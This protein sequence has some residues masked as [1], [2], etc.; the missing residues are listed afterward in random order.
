MPRRAMF[1]AM[2]EQF[3]S[4]ESIIGNSYDIGRGFDS[5]EETG[6]ERSDGTQT[7]SHPVHAG[8]NAQAFSRR[9][10]ERKTEE[11]NEL[12]QALA[13][14]PDART[15]AQQLCVAK[16]LRIVPYLRA[17]YS[18]EEIFKLAKYF[19]LARHRLGDV[20]FPQG[21]VTDRFIV[22]LEGTFATYTND[23]LLEQ[24]RRKRQ[25]LAKQQQHQAAMQSQLG[26]GSSNSSLASAARAV[27]STS[28]EA[29]VAG[30]Q[31]DRAGAVISSLAM[32]IAAGHVP[33]LDDRLGFSTSSLNEALDEARQVHRQDSESLPNMQLQSSALQAAPPSISPLAMSRVP[34]TIDM[35]FTRAPS[36]EHASHQRSAAAAAV[37]AAN[38][39]TNVYR[40]IRDYA[41]NDVV[42]EES[43]GR[44]DHS[45][46]GLHCER[47]GIV[48]V[49]L[50]TDYRK[51][52][53]E[54]ELAMVQLSNELLRDIPAFMPYNSS[55]TAMSKLVDQ[56]A[57]ERKHKNEVILAQGAPAPQHVHIVLEGQCRAT[58]TIREPRHAT[59]AVATLERGS[60][61]GAAAVLADTAQPV[62]V[63][64]STPF[65][66]LLRI[67]R[68]AFL[69]FDPRT[70]A[71]LRGELSTR[72]EDRDR[73][74]R[75]QM[76]TIEDEVAR[77]EARL[78]AERAEANPTPE[79]QAAS[80][81]A[82]ALAMAAAEHK[83]LGPDHGKSD[84]DFVIHGQ[85]KDAT[86]A[87]DL[88]SRLVAGHE[89][90]VESTSESHFKTMRA[91]ETD[92]EQKRRKDA[93]LER[94]AAAERKRKAQKAL[95]RSR[96]AGMQPGG[97]SLPAITGT[98]FLTE[99]G[100]GGDD[101]EDDDDE[102]EDEEEEEEE[103]DEAADAPGLHLALRH[104][105]GHDGSR[106]ALTARRPAA[107]RDATLLARTGS[108]TY[109]EQREQERQPPRREP[110]YP[111]YRFRPVDF[112]PTRYEMFKANRQRLSS[113]WK[114][115]AQQR[116]T[117]DQRYNF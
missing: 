87:S 114:A 70:L 62:T 73:I 81:A 11:R 75:L 69:N 38:D 84:I 88:A 7:P 72:Q 2:S 79:T 6:D 17:K 103:E 67:S 10:R 96:R 43:L 64:A 46:A 5:D 45:R 39:P 44:A 113:G 71:F 57:R 41:P 82:A 99:I 36:P 112:Y 35:S 92:R 61:I 76:L 94:L 40:K 49:M 26:A 77:V 66:R 14:E 102:E 29:L 48:M 65:V 117:T 23:Y 30:A 55:G 12:L 33:T 50:T 98:T 54:H 80:A 85:R 21:H 60:F 74:V 109:R 31:A 78:A 59:L 68:R 111:N 3:E 83:R 18:E 105:I 101:E 28:Q 110:R 37:A 20:V 53:R 32:Q 95:R 115:A 51:W 89:E 1:R 106:G 13:S 108:L 107:P 42:Y 16:R 93:E 58:R 116:P 27:I 90:L 97:V 91:R 56:F 24:Q 63:A 15:D 8:I 19:T 34:S 86:G 47:E 104:T 25:M 100:G 9:R 4:T 22:V 52:A